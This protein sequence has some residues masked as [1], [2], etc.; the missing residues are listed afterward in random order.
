MEE[1]NKSERNL[2]APTMIADLPRQQK[3]ESSEDDESETNSEDWGDT[4]DTSHRRTATPTVKVN[5]M[6]TKKRIC[7]VIQKKTAK[8]LD[9]G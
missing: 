9:S 5:S 3:F 1:I 8:N 4:D 2:V 6:T 7:T